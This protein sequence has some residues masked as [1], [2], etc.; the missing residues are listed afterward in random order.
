MPHN[1][2]TDIKKIINS[3]KLKKINFKYNRITDISPLSQLHDLEWVDLYANWFREINGFENAKNLKYLD[4]TLNNIQSTKGLEGA[5]N[6]E[7]LLIGDALIMKLEGISHMS[8]LKIL[9][10]AYS[11]LKTIEG[12][13][14]NIEDFWIYSDN[15]PYADYSKNMDP[16]TYEI[17]NKYERV[18]TIYSDKETY[19]GPVDISTFLKLKKL[20]MYHCYKC[21]DGDENKELKEK[22]YS[23]FRTFWAKQ[24]KDEKAGFKAEEARSRAVLR[25]H[26][27]A[28]LASKETPALSAQGM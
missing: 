10:I 3:P 16:I 22:M 24:K 19:S 18:G 28:W 17:S 21:F 12:A 8:K 1:S 26:K 20:Y 6:L 9:N 14:L 23:Q 4:I 15:G 25:K 11:S 7:T 5:S 27:I 2:L 13:P